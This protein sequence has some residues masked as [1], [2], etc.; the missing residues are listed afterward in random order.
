M[1]KPY[2]CTI[3]GVVSLRLLRAGNTKGTIQLLIRTSGSGSA[4]S[5]VH[6]LPMDKRVTFA[7]GV[8]DIVVEFYWKP[9][10]IPIGSVTIGF[11]LSV[12]QGKGMPG[13]DATAILT[14][15][16]AGRKQAPPPP[17]QQSRYACLHVPISIL[18][19]LSLFSNA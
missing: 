17:S 8:E 4:K 16:S 2:S 15:E 19:C 11:E 13:D 14:I 18:I 7:D 5:G 3:D 6:Y 12:M 1:L 9:E 10:A